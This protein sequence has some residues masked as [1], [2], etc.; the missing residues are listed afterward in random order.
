LLVVVAVAVAMIH[1]TVAA[2]AALVALDQ[3]LLLLVAVEV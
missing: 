3:L 1:N 2:V